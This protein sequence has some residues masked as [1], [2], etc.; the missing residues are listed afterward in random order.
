LELLA[1][2]RYRVSAKV[3]ESRPVV[4]EDGAIRHR[5]RLVPSTI[6]AGM[7]PVTEEGR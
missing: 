7:A 3:V 4:A 1:S 5:V 2:G 6:D